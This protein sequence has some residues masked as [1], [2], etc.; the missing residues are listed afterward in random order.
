[1]KK[2]PLQ[3]TPVRYDRTHG[4]YRG[5]FN[6]IRVGV[7]LLYFG[8]CGEFTVEAAVAHFVEDDREALIA[9]ALDQQL[10]EGKRIQAVYSIW[11][12]PQPDR[13]PALRRILSEVEDAPGVIRGAA[14]QLVKDRDSQLPAI[15]ESRVAAW[16]DASLSQVLMTVPWTT[17]E[18]EFSTIAVIILREYVE[19]P[20][21][22]RREEL[23]GI[24]KAINTLDRAACFAILTR[25]NSTR[26]LL[27]GATRKYSNSFGP[28]I[29]LA[30]LG[31]L[32]AEDREL[33]QAVFNDSSAPRPAR[34]GA[35]VA[36]GKD[37]EK[38]RRYVLEEITRLVN[39][40]G[41]D[42]V[43][44]RIS[45]LLQSSQPDH[46]ASEWMKE[47]EAELPCLIAASATEDPE[48]LDLFVEWSSLKNEH[49]WQIACLAAVKR[50]PEQ[51]LDLDLSAVR[52]N[53]QGMEGELNSFLATLVICHPHLRER[54]LQHISADELNAQIGILREQGFMLFGL[55]GIAL[56][57]N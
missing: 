31:G 41:A 23:P 44:E 12:L 48:L 53:H 51:F 45:K 21:E 56:I 3:S 4:I 7:V 27:R 10:P 43:S 54:V 16:S 28:W 8:G 14:F 46:E 40:F 2:H 37:H 1:M 6:S 17:A 42:T 38:G 24:L 49:I 5:W 15:V 36:L 57:I 55:P 11:Q 13:G 47:L 29:G 18:N 19:H 33:A 35:A 39:R 52:R 9:Q 25:T 20:R 32:S 50:R 22:L 34:I 26:L 30:K